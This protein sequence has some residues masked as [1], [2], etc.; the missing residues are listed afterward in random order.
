[1]FL[2]KCWV[3]PVLNR[4]F[5]YTFT[6]LK[7]MKKQTHRKSRYRYMPFISA[8]NN[9]LRISHSYILLRS[10]YHMDFHFISLPIYINLYIRFPALHCNVWPIRSKVFAFFLELC[11]SLR[12]IRKMCMSFTASIFNGV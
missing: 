4:K 9:Q 10:T 11:V 7:K 1:M 5:K 2:N 6:C 12:L 3:F 8:F